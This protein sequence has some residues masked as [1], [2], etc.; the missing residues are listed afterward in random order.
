MIAWPKT[1]VQYQQNILFQL[2]VLINDLV[3][4]TNKV[5]NGWL[6]YN[7]RV[8]LRIKGNY[9]DQS[10]KATISNKI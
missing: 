10:D 9:L 1:R 5:L 6:H 7:V 3:T 2:Q 4:L 8:L